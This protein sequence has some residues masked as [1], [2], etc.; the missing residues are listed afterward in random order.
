LDTSNGKVE[1]M[2]MT[3]EPQGYE[4]SRLNAVRHGILS[5]HLVLPWE[6]HSEYDDLLEG[7]VAEHV[8][9][10]TTEHHLV[11]ELASIIWRKQRLVI[12]ETAAYQAGLK[13][14]A[15]DTPWTSERL[16]SRA[17]VHLGV[18]GMSHDVCQAIQAAPED[19]AAELAE[20]EE[21]AAMVGRA[22]EILRKDR[23][24][25]YEK[26]VE[27]LHPCTYDWWGDALH[28]AQDPGTGDCGEDDGEDRPY[29]ADAESL[30][31]F[32]SGEVSPWLVERRL[33]LEN[34]PL[35]RAQA[36]GE[37]LDP[38]RLD[39]LARYEAHLDRKLERVLGMLLKLQDLR[40]TITP[41]TDA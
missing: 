20:L 4:R 34:R 23:R 17:L 3:A 11:E 31:R 14:A 35:I 15:E 12:A 40:R 38:D 2:P 25:A 24:G 22:L 37:A 28:E 1:A 16:T 18:H 27:T 6:D 7:L 21:V 41:P 32:L 19:T 39:K 10:G 26:A 30:E 36:F 9:S 13:R 29:A 33:A 5:R 8:P